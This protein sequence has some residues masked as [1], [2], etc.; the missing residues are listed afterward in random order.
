MPLHVTS[1]V[2]SFLYEQIGVLHRL[3]L[4]MHACG[5]ELRETSLNNH[6]LKLPMV[7]KFPSFDRVLIIL[8]YVSQALPASR[9]LCYLLAGYSATCQQPASQRRSRPRT[10]VDSQSGRRNQ[11]DVTRAFPSIHTQPSR[12]RALENFHFSFNREKQILSFN[13]FTAVNVPDTFARQAAV[14]V[15]LHTPLHVLSPFAACDGQVS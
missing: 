10:K 4:P 8:I 6:L 15:L 9:V 7:G 2:P 5:T 14:N 3:R 13:H 1:Q 12:F 11:N